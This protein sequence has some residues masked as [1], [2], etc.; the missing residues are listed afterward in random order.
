MIHRRRFMRMSWVIT[1][2]TLFYYYQ[3]FLF[4]ICAPV[5]HPIGD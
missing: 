2:S 4:R 3:P 1:P 5:P